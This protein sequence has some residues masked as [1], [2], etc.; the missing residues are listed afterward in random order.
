MRLLLRIRPLIFG[1]GLFVAGV[2]VGTAL[3]GW[4][5]SPRHADLREDAT[6]VSFLPENVMSLSYASSGGMATLQ[7]STPGVPF[8]VLSTFADGRPAQRCSTSADMA[9][10]L[11]NLAALTVRRKLSLEQREGEFPVQLGVIEVRDAIISQPPGPVLVFTSK[12]KTAIAV[13]LD[14]RAAEVTL[15]AEE[16]AWLK[17][18]CS[19][20]AHE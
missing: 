5:S 18:P 10:H 11:N 2:A 9:G 20:L 8:Q 14:G 13:V 7:R 16:L 19:E 3:A 6:L 15:Q 1:A 4:A 12:D 17:T